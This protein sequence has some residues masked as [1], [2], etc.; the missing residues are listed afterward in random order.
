MPS[1]STTTTL[2]TASLSGGT[3]PM[4]LATPREAWP[5]ISTQPNLVMKSG[6]FSGLYNAPSDELIEEDTELSPWPHLSAWW[7]GDELMELYNDGK[8]EKWDWKNPTDS[9][10]TPRLFDIGDYGAVN[11]DGRYPGFI[12]DIFGDWREEV[13]VMSS[14]YSELVLSTADQPSDV[15]LYT[16]AHNRAYRNDM[17]V[18]GYMQTHHV[19]YFLGHDMS[20]P[21]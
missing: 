9:D 8:F 4:K 17:T 18:K 3:T 1:W 14:N 11:M 20:M 13:I 5:A 15:R 10:G 21:P 6:P 19:D 16:L 7:D 12:G 2:Q